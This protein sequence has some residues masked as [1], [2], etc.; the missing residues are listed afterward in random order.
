MAKVTLYVVEWERSKIEA[1]G[2]GIG[3]AAEKLGVNPVK[4]A[5]LIGVTALFEPDYLV[6]IDA[7]AVLA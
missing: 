3:A 6:E 4:S 1:I 2:A 7:T 5:T